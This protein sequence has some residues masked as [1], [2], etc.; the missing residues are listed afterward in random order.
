MVPGG[1]SVLSAPAHR[2]PAESEGD[3]DG[4]E[5]TSS[6]GSCRSGGR[7]P[8]WWASVCAASWTLPLNTLSAASATAASKPMYTS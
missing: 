2:L 8:P 3:V 5:E 1:G 4:V 6:S 7:L